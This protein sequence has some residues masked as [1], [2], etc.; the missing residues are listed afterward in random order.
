MLCIVFPFLVCNAS[1]HVKD[2]QSYKDHRDPPKN[3]SFEVQVLILQMSSHSLT[4]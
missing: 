1:V 4:Y 2:L 3:T